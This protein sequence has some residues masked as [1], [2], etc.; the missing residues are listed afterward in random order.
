LRTNFLIKR[1][2]FKRKNEN[3]L[4]GNKKRFLLAK[5]DIKESVMK[6]VTIISRILLETY[7][8]LNKINC[9]LVIAVFSLKIS[10]IVLTSLQQVFRP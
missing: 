10:K 8:N 3:F 4:I 9:I 2:L 5:I 7:L 1:N 6:I